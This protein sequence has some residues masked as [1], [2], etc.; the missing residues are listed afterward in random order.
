MFELNEL[1]LKLVGELRTIA[2]DLGVETK[3]LKKDAL[4]DAIAAKQSGGSVPAPVPAP[5]ENTPGPEPKAETPKPQTIADYDKA[6]SNANTSNNS[7]GGNGNNNDNRNERNGNGKRKRLVDDKA[8]SLTNE[9][10]EPVADP[11][12]EA[13]VAQADT[14]TP[15]A[16]EPKNI[17]PNAQEKKVEPA[18]VEGNTN[19]EVTNT[20]TTENNGGR[21]L[22]LSSNNNSSKTLNSNKILIRIQTKT[23]IKTK[24]SNAN[25]F[26]ARSTIKARP[27]G[28]NAHTITDTNKKSHLL[29]LTEL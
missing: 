28:S 21:M 16:E 22:I 7:N 24:I 23:R 11:V 14:V 13:P 2:K 12:V 3:D 8:L 18:V 25:V 15:A 5:V 17:D 10:P 4:I 20:A 6:Q 27:V 19:T 29:S 1:K 26:S 9:E